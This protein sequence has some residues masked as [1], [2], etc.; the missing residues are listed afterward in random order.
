MILGISG[1]ALASTRSLAEVLALLRE[2]DVRWIELWPANLESG[3]DP[4]RRYEGKD[5]ARAEEVL[6]EYGIG[7]ACV[8]MPA[9]FSREAAQDREGYLTALKTAV[10]VAERLGAHI[11]NSYCFHWALSHDADVG[12]IV[13]MLRSAAAY[14]GDKGVTLVLENEA[15]DASGTVAG[16]LRILEAAGSEALKTNFDA[17]NYYQAGEEGFPY[18]YNK[19][20]DHIAYVHLK[21]GCAHDPAIHGEVGR[22]GTMPR[23]GEDRYI[24]YCPIPEGAV[25]IE[26][27]LAK[28]HQDRF[29]GFCTIEP[30]VPPDSVEQY[31]RAEVPYLRRHAVH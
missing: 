10:D 9:A 25:N 23:L 12:P 30:H 13:K 28:L 21:N 17:T 26:G 20:K 4:G 24:H 5:V 8:T 31:Y 18:A 19:L 3:V 6:N 1:Q 7:V 14:A 16:M 11:V 29:D 15:H 27:L 2:L 22:G